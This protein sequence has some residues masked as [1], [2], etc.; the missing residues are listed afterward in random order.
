MPS[1]S[2]VP[3]PRRSYFTR[4]GG[5]RA[6]RIDRFYVSPLLSDFVSPSRGRGTGIGCD[7]FS[8]HR[9]I[10][11]H[12]RPRQ[13]QPA[14]QRR[15]LP[16][17]RL[18][19]QS[20]AALVEDFERQAALLIG[21][22]PQ[23]D[24]ALFRWWPRFKARLAAL[25]RSLNR[26]RQRALDAPAEELQQQLMQLYARCEDG[27]DAAIEAIIAAR[28][29]LSDLHVAKA[30]QQRLS[31]LREWLHDGEKPSRGLTARLRPPAAA[32]GVA[33]LRDAA[34]QLQTD[35]QSCANTMARY[36]AN[37]SVQPAV[38]EAAKR[39]VLAALR[40]SPR[41]SAEHAA[42]LDSA[43]ITAADINAS[44]RHVKSG[45][46]PGADGL[47]LELFRRYK[48]LFYPL[49]ARLFSAI[50]SHSHLPPHFH[51]GLMIT[52]YKA[53]DR[54]DPANYRP[55]TLLNH[56]YR[57]FTRLLAQRL[58]TALSGVIDRQQTA[59]LPDRS[60]GENIQTMQ[61]LPGL[62]AS[63]QQQSVAVM[64]DFRKAYDTVDRGFLRE[65]MA[66]MGAGVTFRRLTAALLTGT[67]ASAHVNGSLSYPPSVFAAGVRQGCPLSP[68]L[69]LFV[70][71]ALGR[72]LQADGFGITVAGVQ[73]PALQYAD[74]LTA[75]LN[76]PAQLP[77]FMAT[78]EV[79]AAASG[80][81]L[82]P[83]KTK[84]ML[85]G[86]PS[87][88][89]TAA[90]T[91]ATAAGGP[92]FVQQITYLGIG[93]SGVWRGSRDATQLTDWERLV[94][95]VQQRQDKIAS[96]QLSAF[97]RGIASSA[98]A[99]SALLYHAEF[100]GLPTPASLEQLR[101]DAAAL[102][103]RGA[104][105]L[106]RHGRRFSGIRWD[107]QF[108]QPAAGGIGVLPLVAH[109]T[110]R[111]ATWAVRLVKQLASERRSPWA[112][113]AEASLR[114][115]YPDVHPL[116]LIFQRYSDPEDEFR[117][118]APMRRLLAALQT[119]PP[120]ELLTAVQPGA[121]CASAQLW[122]NPLLDLQRAQQQLL[123]MR[124]AFYPL[125]MSGFNTIPQL[126][127]A[128]AAM[129]QLRPAT[130]GPAARRRI[131]TASVDPELFMGYHG[132]KE[133]LDECSAAVPP[134]WKAAAQL[135]AANPPPPSAAAKAAIAALGWKLEDGSTVTFSGLTVR[136]ATG[137]QL[138]EVFS[139][140]RERHTAFV[141]AAHQLSGAEAPAD[142]AAE[143]QRLLPRLWKVKCSNQPV[144]EFYWRLVLD[145]LPTA[146]RRHAPQGEANELCFC[147]APLPDRK[148]LC[149]GCPAAKCVV[150]ALEAELQSFSERRRQQQAHHQQP[151]QRQQ[152]PNMVILQQQQQQLQQEQ[153]QQEPRQEPPAAPQG[154]YLP[155]QGDGQQQQ[156]QQ[157]QQQQRRQ[158]PAAAA[159]TQLTAVDVW[160]VK[161]PAGVFVGIWQLV[162][163]AALAAMDHARK[164]AFARQQ[165][166]GA[167]P[168]QP[169]AEYAAALGRRSVGW[170]WG[171][172]A[173]FCALGMAPAAWRS[174]A[175]HGPFIRYSRQSQRWEVARSAGGA[176]RQ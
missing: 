42:L 161:K 22:Q 103:D 108:G 86:Q 142:P 141:E 6:S 111:H 125:G 99:V 107:L 84:A 144:K 24:E 18:Q 15:P 174:A 98:Y 97:G 53:G 85:L 8:D 45:T 96:L 16:R 41:I 69:Y 147:G 171:Q 52:L 116:T 151:Q 25:C 156:R 73:L 46:S 145:A 27:D 127:A 176:Q 159:G 4:F 75:L 158:Q 112:A 167:Q 110:A 138:G 87:P 94:S 11:M 33:V 129:R 1:K 146:A 121:W 163:M 169:G 39:R 17:L 65:V 57:I 10:A 5:G 170:F 14:H 140:R 143:I 164:V 95:V 118:L 109:V 154:M 2:K 36:F 91:A 78:M 157:E 68:L 102:A 72:L 83:Q 23:G 134:A 119:L 7:G 70:A 20:D 77:A 155:A 148:H 12:L 55:I 50:I 43:D 37:V 81:R 76:S 79:F 124:E 106:K 59:F 90:A 30:G 165:E 92:Q 160:L 136:A 88:A 29:Q 93:Y 175:V 137:M 115:A 104:S 67:A 71:Q 35:S 149:W 89:T 82:N 162:C 152:Q 26:Q 74:D 123:P 19:F 172:M 62:L 58:G 173:E 54:A 120:P 131:F 44:L 114:L 135:A 56:D 80:Q 133:V 132:V 21:T 61:L 122:D 63:R 60:I 100:A 168:A 34:D 9:L 28:R 31:E 101:K 105:P 49:L 150:A 130:Y 128:V 66:A 32:R 126:E 47:P 3:P 64:C 48:Q 38:D 40:G 166:A 51:D 117:L 153:A 113:I 13:P 139:E